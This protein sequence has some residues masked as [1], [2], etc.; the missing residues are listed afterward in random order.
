MKKNIIKLP[1]VA[2]IFVST[3]SV[4]ALTVQVN[5]TNGTS[6]QPVKKT[7]SIKIISLKGEMKEEASVDNQGTGYVFKNLPDTPGTPYMVQVMYDGVNY[8]KVLPPMGE[9]D[10]TADIT[11]YNTVNKFNSKIHLRQIYQVQYYPH[12]MAVYA[13]FHFFNEDNKTFAESGKE[14]GIYMHIPPNAKDVE[15]SAS[16]GNM[17]SNIQWLKVIPQQVQG[18]EDIY[19]LNQPVKPGEKFYQV[20]YLFPYEGDEVSFVLKNVYPQSGEP[21]LILDSEGMDVS[22]SNLPNWKAAPKMNKDLG[23]MVINVPLS[24][25]PL[26]LTFKGGKVMPLPDSEMTGG[27]SEGSGGNVEVLSPVNNYQKAGLIV[28]FFVLAILFVEYVKRNPAWIQMIRAKN[29][30]RLEFEKDSLSKLAISEEIKKKK[31]ASIDK[32]LNQLKSRQG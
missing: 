5:I 12:K 25:V 6:G 21:M 31:M 13:V 15:I 4:N 20:R 16:V 2:L 29:I 14:K 30:G 18:R 11:V 24:E 27:G 26:S 10:V 17:S 22:I 23:A 32:K 3:F 8:N 7:E 1:L 19:F 9:T 28:A